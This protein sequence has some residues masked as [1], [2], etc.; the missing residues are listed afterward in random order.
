M[1]K[2]QNVVTFEEEIGLR[3]VG[4]SKKEAFVEVLTATIVSEILSHIP[5]MPHNQAQAIANN[6]V[7]QLQP[8]IKLIF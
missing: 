4:I 7:M 5:E 1:G 2:N 6:T 8:V 3:L